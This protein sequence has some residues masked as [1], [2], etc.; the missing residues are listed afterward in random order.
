MYVC[1]ATYKII[2]RYLKPANIEKTTDQKALLFRQIRRGSR[3]QADR[4]TDIS[5]HR[6]IKH[7]VKLAS[8][9][10][11]IQWKLTHLGR[12]DMNVGFIGLGNMGNPMAAN[13]LK[14]QYNLTVHDLRREMGQPLEELPAQ[15]GGQARKT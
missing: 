7:R 5:A 15:S 4:F 6:I 2:T 12:I 14:A 13:L 11:F 3:V 9:S 8:V 1:S 10:G